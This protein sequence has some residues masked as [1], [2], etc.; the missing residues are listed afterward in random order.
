[1][2][3]RA[4]Y[5]LVYLASL[6][7]LA[8]CGLAESAPSPSSGSDHGNPRV[9]AVLQV[10]EDAIDDVSGSVEWVRCDAPGGV[11]CAPD[12]NPFFFPCSG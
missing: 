8:G 3:R 7:V 5:R 9:P 2:K 1:M 12:V 4:A 6:G 11:C 10:L